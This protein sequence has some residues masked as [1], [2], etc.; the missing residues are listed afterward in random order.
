MKN[1]VDT[2]LRRV[3]TSNLHIHIK[4]KSFGAIII[5]INKFISNIGSVTLMIYCGI[6]CA[7]KDLN[8]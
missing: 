3:F 5:S 4:Q 6:V 8:T 7:L 1:Y 2:F